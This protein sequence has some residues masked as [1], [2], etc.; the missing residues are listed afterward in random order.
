MR[1]KAASIRDRLAPLAAG[2]HRGVDSNGVLRL[3]AMDLEVLGIR[4]AQSLDTL[5]HAVVAYQRADH[6][7]PTTERAAAATARRV[8]H[9]PSSTP[10]PPETTGETHHRHHRAA[11][12]H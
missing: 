5:E 12:R 2:N 1:A 11:P 7:P 10:T 8:P 9:G 4:Y 3:G 6:A